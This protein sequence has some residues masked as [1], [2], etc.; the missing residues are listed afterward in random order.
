MKKVTYLS[1]GA[2][3]QSSLL[4]LMIAHGDLPEYRDAK[5]IFADTGD[6]MPETYRYLNDHLEPRL[7]ELGYA[8]IRVQNFT[9]PS[10]RLIDRFWA[11]GKVPMGWVNPL[12]SSSSKKNVIHAY[13]REQHGIKNKNGK[14]YL[15]SKHVKIIQLLGISVDEITRAKHAR[16]NWLENRY[17]LIDL[18]L[19]R[20]DL[21]SQ[22]EKYGLPP[23]PKSGC[24]YCPN[25]GKQYFLR[26]QEHHPSWHDELQEV[27]KHAALIAILEDREIPTFVH[28]FSLLTDKT[29]EE[30][31]QIA[32][33]SK[34]EF[35]PTARKKL[36]TRYHLLRPVNQLRLEDFDDFFADQMCDSGY[37]M[38]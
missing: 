14:K 11:Q 30:V 38:T 34:G 6:E 35:N 28:N 32:L 16:E 2:G 15:S 18:G 12:C 4:A 25:R 27:E 20:S 10:G 21:P 9:V 24:W 36:L 23:A 33:C 8:I 22:Y 5:I 26:M 1:L 7:N 31:I 3:L 29:K 13:Y 37:C 19:Y 17:P